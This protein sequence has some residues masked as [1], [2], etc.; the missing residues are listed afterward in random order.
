[1]SNFSFLES[2][3]LPNERESQNPQYSDYQHH[4]FSLEDSEIRGEASFIEIPVEL[5]EF[6]QQ[7]GYGFFYQN[8]DSHADRL[9]DVGNFKK[10]NLR[11]DFYEFD[12]DLELYDD[13]SYQD[14]FIFFEL[15]EGVYLLISKED[16]K[17]KNEIHFFDKKIADSLEEF[18]I[19]FDSEGHYFE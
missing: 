8:D 2:Y 10:I 11:Q 15:N 5:R 1:M 9:L 3:I 19:R 18:L 17:G 13:K 7:V 4:L 14:K 16:K 6:Y 12:P